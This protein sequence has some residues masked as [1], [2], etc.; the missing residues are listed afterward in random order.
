MKGEIFKGYEQESYT[1]MQDIDSVQREE[2]ES[3][4]YEIDLLNEAIK[5]DIF[6]TRDPNDAAMLLCLGMTLAK[7][8]FC[9]QMVYGKRTPQR[10]VHFGFS[11]HDDTFRFVI[12]SKLNVQSSLIYKNINAGELRM[13]QG[14]IKTT[15]HSMM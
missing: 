11:G 2:V 4:V 15:L 3:V 7:I 1:R 13:Y 6:Y 8:K 10:V 9:K 14:I 12:R 5:E